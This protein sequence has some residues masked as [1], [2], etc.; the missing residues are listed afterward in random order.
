MTPLKGEIMTAEESNV[1]SS[2]EDEAEGGSSGSDDGF[3]DQV[4][5][6]SSFSSGS[7]TAKKRKNEESDTGASKKLKKNTTKTPLTADELIYLKETENMFQS[8][9]FRLQISELVNETKPKKT[10]KRHFN[11]W[12]ENFT[13][14]L[15]GLEETEEIEV[16]KHIK[17]LKKGGVKFPLALPG[18][19]G[20]IKCKFSKPVKSLVVG[21]FQN[22]TSLG[23]PVTVDVVLVMPKQLFRKSDKFDQQY[24]VKRSSYLC[25]VAK[26]LQKTDLITAD[27]S[28]E[29]TAKNGDALK[30]HLVLRPNEK[31]A[32]ALTVVI[33]AVAEAGT[34]KL[35]QFTPEKC[36][37]TLA[38]KDELGST[39]HYNATI[40]E[41]LVLEA[42]EELKKSMF[43]TNQHLKEAAVLLGVWL[44]Q[45]G[46][47]QGYGAFNMH[48]VCMYLAF[49]VKT[50]RINL[51]MNSNQIIRTFWLDIGKTDW[52]ADGPSLAKES[53]DSDVPAKTLFHGH[54][55]V[56]FVDVTGFHNLAFKMSWVTYSKVKKE[57]SQAIH[58][59]NKSDSSCFQ[60]LFLKSAPF[61][62]QY[63][64][65]ICFREAEVVSRC[66]QAH[67][68]QKQMMDFCGQKVPVFAQ[69]L[70]P[71]LE[72]GL[73][74]RLDHV[75]INFPPDPRWQL[76]S[77]NPTFNQFGE[78]LIG[79][80][81]NPGTSL[82]VID[83][84]PPSNTPEGSEFRE[85]W[86]D[87]CQ[88]RRF[89]DGSITESVIWAHNSLPVEQ[90]RMI[91]KNIVMYL[92]QEKLN[93][94][95]HEFSYVGF[96]LSH[97]N[98]ISFAPTRSIE[99]TSISFHKT[100][101]RLS[102]ELHGLKLPLEIV[103][104]QCISEI[105]RF[106]DPFPPFKAHFSIVDNLCEDTPN[107]FL[108]KKSSEAMLPPFTSS[109]DLVVQMST[110]GKWPDDLNACK[111]LV[112]AFYVEISK[113]FKEK[114][115]K[116]QVTPDFLEVFRD[117]FIFRIFLAYSKQIGILK[118][119]IG[120][121]GLK[122]YRDTDESVAIEKK[123]INLPKLTGALYGLSQQCSAFAPTCVLAKRW[124]SS[125]LLHE[126]HFPSI[127]IEL[128]V[129]NMFLSSQPVEVTMHPLPM[130]LRFLKILS[131]TNWNL[132]PVI[133]NFNDTLDR[134]SIADVEKF[135][136]SNRE[137]LPPIFL[138]T[139]FD[140]SGVL[141]TRKS[142]TIPVLV[143]LA[144]L[145]S[146][147]LKILE[148]TLGDHDASSKVT[149]IFRP[150][151][152]V[153][154]LVI[155]L[156][157]ET[158]TRRHQKLDFHGTINTKVTSGSY[159]IPIYN[160]DPVELYI[161]DLEVHYN[162]KAIF[163]YDRY[164][165]CEIGVLLK[166]QFL[167]EVPFKISSFEGRK[168]LTEGAESKMK[169]D[170]DAL[171]EGFKMLG[172]GVVEDVILNGHILTT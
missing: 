156:K 8:N 131:T 91:V 88:L 152:S 63:D 24:L 150:P 97:L 26:E 79:V 36:N 160:F 126:T 138:V 57:A 99:E 51:S 56:V 171:I 52:T 172:S 121:S 128:L 15:D 89:K 19:A 109:V 59:L 120:E 27:T 163:F 38:S 39:P 141:W 145:A 157:P 13:K 1:S 161:Q 94:E 100:F 3:D 83:K 77:P 103:S 124:V 129:A 71:L 166:P 34:F 23:S 28:I 32:K 20:E 127:V 133:V 135:F 95:E 143:R 151:M 154:H 149:A 40:S 42:N 105:Y 4:P 73:G 6:L 147:S 68:T 46:L 113:A 21:S 81:L 116:T 14:F 67:A 144:R 130:F 102:N 164:G 43:E 162:D 12:F 48:I 106:T 155:R 146:V 86:G 35:T 165:G 123:F 78:I 66:V 17:L 29:F 117:G 122:Q 153:F 110:S 107:G 44:R 137:T 25:H 55:E 49:M 5:D 72:K 112:A 134:N 22:G 70:I 148:T 64:N 142:P 82:S 92:L 158:A 80:K 33:S 169:P 61:L 69:L 41:D 136:T 132:E 159:N 47:S 85:F 111:R 10:Y 62:H 108:L 75:G 53:P 115:Y 50:R 87:K 18:N 84:G 96:Q 119:R 170:F 54:H 139:P 30:P 7:A 104:V 65:V 168:L 140:P 2:E 125:Q 11:E 58:L 16:K 9:V 37:F 118:Q 93:I 60:A 98:Q 45:R 74:K 167:A 114:R 101:T 31:S 90:R 76:D